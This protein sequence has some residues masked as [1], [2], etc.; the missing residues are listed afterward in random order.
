MRLFHA[1]KSAACLGIFSLRIP[2]LLKEAANMRV[3]APRLETFAGWLPNYNL[4]YKL[5]K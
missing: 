5:Q 1:Q 4:G 3:C 2:F